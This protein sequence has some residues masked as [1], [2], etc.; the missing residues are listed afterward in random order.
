MHFATTAS[1]GGHSSILIAITPEVS[2]NLG[3]CELSF[4]P[5]TAIDVER[6]AG[7]AT[8]PDVFVQDETPAVAAS[9]RDIALVHGGREELAIAFPDGVEAVDRV[10]GQADDLMDDGVGHRGED[11]L[12]VAVVFRPQLAVDKP[13]EVGPSFRFQV[14]LRHHATHRAPMR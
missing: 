9:D 4:V 3:A 7:Q 1:P 14:M 8:A 13:I 5:R 10:I 12:D 2:P 11:P 6:A